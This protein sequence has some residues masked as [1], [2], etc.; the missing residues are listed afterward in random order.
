MLESTYEKKQTN[1]NIINL[2]TWI[3]NFKVKSISKI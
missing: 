2:W 1:N 3:Q